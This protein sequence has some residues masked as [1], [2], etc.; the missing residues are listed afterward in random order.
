MADNQKTIL[1]EDLKIKGNVFEKE[2]IQINGE[3]VVLFIL[4]TPGL[5]DMKLDQYSTVSIFGIISLIS[6]FMIYN[7]EK[8]V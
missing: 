3:D 5:F 2:N 7:I 4:D 8:R 1:Q 6:S